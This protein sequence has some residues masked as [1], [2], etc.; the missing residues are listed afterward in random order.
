MKN[1]ENG[2]MI[3]EVVDL[4]REINLEV[5]SDYVQEL[6]DFLNLEPTVDVIEIQMQDIE[7]LESSDPLQ[8]EDRMIKPQATT[9]RVPY[10]KIPSEPFFRYGSPVSGTVV[11]HA[12]APVA[13]GPRTIDTADATVATPQEKTLKN[14]RS[15]L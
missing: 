7:E 10:I 6:L 2:N 11:T 3:E 15:V 12:E 4:A 5:D 13:W 9:L 8:S 14:E 1:G